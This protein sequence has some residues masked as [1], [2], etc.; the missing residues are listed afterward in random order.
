MGSAAYWYLEN[1]PTRYPKWDYTYLY[2]NIYM[3]LKHMEEYIIG[4]KSNRL[5]SKLYV[6][7]YREALE[8]AGRIMTG[9]LYAGDGCMFETSWHPHIDES[10][11]THIIYLNSFQERR[12]SGRKARLQPAIYIIEKQ[13]VERLAYLISRYSTRWWD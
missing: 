4:H 6:R 9:N 13:H 3:S 10:I 11:K 5:F 12:S 8:L 2:R 7:R 1:A